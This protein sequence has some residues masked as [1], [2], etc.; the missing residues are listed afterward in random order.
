MI[1]QPSQREGERN[2]QVE[3]SI[4]KTSPKTTTHKST[5]RKG[6]WFAPSCQVE[7]VLLRQFHHSR[8]F[9]T[10][11]L[12]LTD[13]HLIFIEPT[14]AQETWVSRMILLSL[15]LSPP[16]LSLAPTSLLFPPPPPS[17]FLLLHFSLS[18]LSFPFPFPPFFSSSSSFLVSITLH[19][20]I[21]K[22]N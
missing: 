22:S 15:L 10:G 14:G 2:Q 1:L 13:I 9:V 3:D 5:T 6:S 18:I 19:L 21:R 8:E 7:P 4:C 11:A 17:L 20:G 16:F 12:C